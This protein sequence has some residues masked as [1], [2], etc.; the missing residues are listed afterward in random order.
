MFFSDWYTP[1]DICVVLC[2]YF[3]ACYH[4]A[5]PVVCPNTICTLILRL[6]DIFCQ[7]AEY[8]IFGNFQVS[9]KEIFIT[10]SVCVHKLRH[11]TNDTLICYRKSPDS[12]PFNSLHL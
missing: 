6:W 3:E 5:A 4:A 12:S 7:V 11:Y 9:P 10:H 8:S 1:Q 2:L